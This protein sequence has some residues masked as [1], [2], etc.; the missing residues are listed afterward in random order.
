ML[1]CATVCYVIVDLLGHQAM[2]LR[3]LFV[4]MCLIHV[5]LLCVLELVELLVL[6]A[7][8]GGTIHSRIYADGRSHLMLQD[9]DK[10]DR[11][12]SAER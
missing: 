4:A 9:F 7:R 6:K 11:D 3:V 10:Q 12:V 1:G 2:S 5:L 8:A